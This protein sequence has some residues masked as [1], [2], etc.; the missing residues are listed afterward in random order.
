MQNKKL[1]IPQCI[2]QVR[3]YFNL[4]TRTGVIATELYVDNGKHWGPAARRYNLVVGDG[5]TVAATTHEVDLLFFHRY[6]V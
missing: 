5:E 1:E 6:I 4:M 2:A 3:T